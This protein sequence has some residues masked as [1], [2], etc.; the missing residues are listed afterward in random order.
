[1]RSIAPGV[2]LETKYPGVIQGLIVT[3]DGLLL[4]D[5]PPRAEDG[6]NWLAALEDYGKPRYLILLDSHPDRVLGARI[7]DLPIVAHDWT[8]QLMSNWS[9][10]F[11]GGTRPIGA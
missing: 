10:T 6:R 8:R 1:M 9:D 2:Y 4:I 7:L 11:K 3:N 5:C